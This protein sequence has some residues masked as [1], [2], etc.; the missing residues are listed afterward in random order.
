MVSAY[1]NTSYI[2]RLSKGERLVEN[3][4]DFLSEHDVKSAWLNMIGAVSEVELGFYNLETKAY[5]WRVVSRPLEITG[6]QGNVATDESGK[7]VL[8]LHGT[9]AD[10]N[11]QVVGG[12]IKDLMVGGTCEIIVRPLSVQLS[13]RNDSNTGLNLLNL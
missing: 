5:Q 13:R 10:D 12:H 6:A 1:D 4:L 8:H 2:V 9:F 7:I 3:V 11:Y